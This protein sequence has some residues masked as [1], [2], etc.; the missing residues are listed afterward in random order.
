MTTKHYCKSIPAGAGLATFLLASLLGAGCASSGHKKGNQTAAHIQTA[1]N[2]IAALPNGIDKT[3]TALGQLVNQPAADLRPQYKEFVYNLAVMEDAGKEIVDAR[4]ALGQEGKAYFAEW[5]AQLAQMKNEDIRARSQSRKHEVAQQLQ[6]VK[7]SYAEAE[8]AY[9]PFI[10]GLKDV[11][12]YLSVDLTPGGL[13]AIKDT[14]TRAVAD[15]GPL[16]TSLARLA[17]DF[18]ALGVAMSSVTPPPGK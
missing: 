10:S 5:D 12:K 15:A 7:K 9:R 14:V 13:A 4:I 11:Q 6:A 17:D 18:R 2:H 1:A 8:V 3:L 16:K